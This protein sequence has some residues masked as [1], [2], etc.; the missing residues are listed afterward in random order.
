MGEGVEGGRERGEKGGEEGRKGERKWSK[1]ARE[2]GSEGGR[3]SGSRFAVT[4]C[5]V[6]RTWASCFSIFNLS[7]LS[8]IQNTCLFTNSKKASL[9][10]VAALL[11]KSV[12]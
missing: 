7:W 8:P 12:T 9:S 2:Q 3:V 5:A 4:S 6:G 10:A 11:L 1:G